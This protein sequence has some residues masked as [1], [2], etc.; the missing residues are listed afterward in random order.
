MIDKKLPED[1]E[2]LKEM[3]ADSYYPTFL[4]DKLKSTIKEVVAFI[5]RGNHNIEE[6][7]AALDQMTLKI[8][9]LSEEFE[10]NESEIETVAG[11]SIAETVQR[12]LSLFAIDID[13]EEALRQRDW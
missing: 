7:Q 11:D 12:I 1:F 13:I 5:E 6:I 2:Y 4:V 9:E 3:Y 8:N 10:E